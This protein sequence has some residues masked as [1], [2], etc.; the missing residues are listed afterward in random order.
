MVQTQILIHWK[1]ARLEAATWKQLSSFQW[2]F[3]DFITAVDVVVEVDV[4]DIIY[5]DN[6]YLDL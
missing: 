3:P 4:V 5:N 1:H 2:L 6:Y